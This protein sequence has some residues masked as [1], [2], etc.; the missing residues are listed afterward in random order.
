M[1]VPVS[2]AGRSAR[3]GG[4]RRPR[5]PGVE[6]RGR[7]R[8]GARR[9]GLEDPPGRAIRNIGCPALAIATSW[10]R[11]PAFSARAR[12]V[13]TLDPDDHDVRATR[14]PPPGL[15]LTGPTASG[16]TAVGLE[17]AG[18]MGAEIVA[19]DSMTLYRGLDIG[20]AKPTEA[21]RRRIPHHLIDILDPWESAQ[22]RGLSRVGRRTAA[23]DIAARGKVALFVGGTPLY[24]KALLR[25]VETMFDPIWQ[26]MDV[27]D[28]TAYKIG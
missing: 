21:E 18:T 26:S 3:A 24:L 22:R 17:L 13:P 19:M 25:R 16:K 9:G 14:P 28:L 6:A 12:P 10:E 8:R 23:A 1:V 2:I 15:Y 27:S 5:P 4:P 7:R 20:T 11:S